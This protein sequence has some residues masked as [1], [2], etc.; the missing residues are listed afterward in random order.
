[1]S[2]TSRIER[3]RPAVVEFEGGRTWIADPSELIQRASHALVLEEGIW[4]I[5]PV[6]APGIT[7]LIDDL[8]P[9]AGVV[10]LLDRH[11]RDAAAFANRYDCSV[12]IPERF[13]GVSKKLDA[14]IERFD[15]TGGVRSAG[16]RSDVERFD[17]ER[18][19]VKRS[20]GERSDG[21]ATLGDSRL[22]AFVVGDSRLF[23]E[24]G[25]YDPELGTLVVP[26]TLGTA[27]YFR[28]GAERLGVNPLRRFKP[29]RSRFESFEP[30]RVLVGHG[31]PVTTDATEALH[32]AL[33]GTRRRIPRLYVEA[34]RRFL[35]I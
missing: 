5:D 15:D 4:L 30:E 27:A 32:Y 2:S 24:T 20:D 18:S 6:D 12:W 22:E 25:L 16:E 21:F 9:V 34:F 10:V 3:V 8:G 11:T 19:D 28:T 29:P 1:M 26:E 23:R 35:P 14:P 17:G 33:E 13:D 7:A 31:R